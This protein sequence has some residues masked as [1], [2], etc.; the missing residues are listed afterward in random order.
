MHLVV[1]PAS[2]PDKLIGIL[3]LIFGDGIFGEID[4]M[5]IA[6]QVEAIIAYAGVEASV[7]GDVVVPAAAPPFSVKVEAVEV[8][9]V[10]KQTGCGRD[11][12][13]VGHDK[14]VCAVTGHDR[15]LN[16]GREIVTAAHHVDIVELDIVKLLN[17]TVAAEYRIV[18]HVTA[19]L[20]VEVIHTVRAHQNVEFRAAEILFGQA[21]HRLGG[22]GIGGGRRVR[23]DIF[24]RIATAGGQTL[25]CQ[26]QGKD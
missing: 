5:R 24:G 4:H 17:L 8:E 25:C 16:G 7:E 2:V 3:Q 22:G 23:R 11:E 13:V 26:K 1:C 19:L 12:I 20:R 10:E 21:E 15:A 9:Q 18:K 6:Q 14:I